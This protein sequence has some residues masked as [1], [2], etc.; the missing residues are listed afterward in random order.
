MFGLIRHTEGD[1]GAIPSP[2]LHHAGEST[3]I[4][5]QYK[6]AN[7]SLLQILTIPGQGITLISVV[8]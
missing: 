5:S 2:V 7:G 6:C 3:C 8:C 4:L 1:S